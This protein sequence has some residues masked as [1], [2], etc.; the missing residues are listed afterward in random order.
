MP[1][2][3]YNILILVGYV[4]FAYLLNWGIDKLW[5]LYVDWCLERPKEKFE[6]IRDPNILRRRLE[7][8]HAQ[9]QG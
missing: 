4:A 8:E 3:T 2:A 9:A 7:Q 6:E 5:W 1:E